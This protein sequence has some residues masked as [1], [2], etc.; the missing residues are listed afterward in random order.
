MM[1]SI[2]PEHRRV[3]QP[4]DEQADGGKNPDNTGVDGL[5]VEIAVKDFG[6]LMGVD[7]AEGHAPGFDDQPRHSLD[8]PD[9]GFPPEQ[10]IHRDD[11]RHEDIQQGGGEIEDPLEIG[12][13]PVGRQL[14]ADPGVDVLD[15]LLQVQIFQQAA[16]LG[17]FGQECHDVVIISR[18]RRDEVHDRV[19]K[20]GERQIPD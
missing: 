13:N 10:H 20:G 1:P 18:H 9:Q 14:A 3:G 7:A 2:M 6:D 8:R 11:E 17:I 5:A 12:E 15:P 16:L 4:G 19:V